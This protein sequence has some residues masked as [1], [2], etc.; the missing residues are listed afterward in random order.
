M[1]KLF[2]LLAVLAALTMAG[3]AASGGE[4]VTPPVEEEIVGGDTSAEGGSDGTGEGEEQPG[5]G[6]CVPEPPNPQGPAGH[7]RPGGNQPADRADL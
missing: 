2:V 1:K 6:G 4:L 5:P 7:D 3:C